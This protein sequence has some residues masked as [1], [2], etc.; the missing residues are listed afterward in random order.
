MKFIIYLPQE[1]S[2]L[3][4]TKQDFPLHFFYYKRSTQQHWQKIKHFIILPHFIYFPRI[5]S[6]IVFFPNTTW[7]SLSCK[8]WEPKLSNLHRWSQTLPRFTRV[9]V[10]QQVTKRNYFTLIASVTKEVTYAYLLLH[11]HSEW[12]VSR[13]AVSLTDK[14]CII[15]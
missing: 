8:D 9:F 7:I 3:L 5:N 10:L 2:A 14:H 12:K 4:R 13:H 11:A 6:N 1:I 15:V